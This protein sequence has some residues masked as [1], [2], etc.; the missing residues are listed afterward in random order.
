MIKKLLQKATDMRQYSHV[1]HS[2]FRVGSA[3][4]TNNGI[5]IGGCNIESDSYGLTICAERNAIFAAYAQGYRQFQALAVVTNSQSTPCGA[6][7]Q[8]IAE[9]CGNIPVYTCDLEGNCLTFQAYDLLP[10]HF[11]LQEPL[12]LENI[13]AHENF[14]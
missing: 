13:K 14:I 11:S 5:I 10:N 12:S 4:L 9:L 2:N 1:P 6:C 8:I 3:L 7:R